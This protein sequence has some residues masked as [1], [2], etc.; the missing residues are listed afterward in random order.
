MATAAR[1][2]RKARPA[3]TGGELVARFEVRY[4]RFL[5]ERGEWVAEPPAE[6]LDPELQLRNYRD[7]LLLRRF[8]HKVLM[9][10]RTGRMG[11]YPGTMGQEAVGVGMAR[12]L[13]ERD[14]LVP[15]YRSA[16]DLYVRGAALHEI[17]LYWMGDERGSDFKAP[18]M[19]HDFPI[20][21]CIGS[22]LPQAAGVA[23]AI[24]LRGEQGR[25]VL[26]AVGDGGTSQ[27]D[28]YETLN[29]AGAWNLPLVI[30]INNNRWAL[31]EPTCAQTACQ[32]LAQKAVAGGFEGIQVDGNDIFAV[33]AAVAAAL[34][35]A[36][37]GQGP[38]LI[39]ALTYRLCAHTTIDNAARY[40]PKEELEA[41]NAAE[42][43]V[44]LR[45]WLQNQ[46]ILDDRLEAKLEN[47]IKD[48]IEQEV[49]L[50]LNTPLPPPE[51]MFDYL[52]AELPEKLWPQRAE[53]IA[54]ERGTGDA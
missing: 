47:E 31:T 40:V 1:G 13:T 52:Y 5:D 35:K 17:L 39:E 54:R 51:A 43:L 32:T 4:L 44:R 15:Y 27:G 8:D 22:Q 42:P 23:T 36:R 37:R 38:T 18:H 33:Q 41:A 7:M 24:K 11:T 19:K 48:E 3:G 34:D 9:L 45:R 20:P 30:V 2:G 53:V 26:T 49:E 46:G 14:V 10:H 12:P 16:T 50:A 29:V 6:L 25:A 28:F 21:I